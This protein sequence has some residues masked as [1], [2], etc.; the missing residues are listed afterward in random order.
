VAYTT[1]TLQEF[2]NEVRTHLGQP[3]FWGDA[4]LDC[5]V[6]ETLR[7]WNLLTGYWTVRQTITASIGEHWY[8]LSGGTFTLI[9]RVSWMG[10]ALHPVSL[11]ERD[12]ADPGWD[13]STNVGTPRLWMPVALDRFAISPAPDLS[14]R[15]ILVDGV[16]ATPTPILATDTINIDDGLVEPLTH[17]TKHLALFKV[18]SDLFASTE[19]ERKELWE[20]ASAYNS[21]LKST[22]L[23]RNVVGKTPERAFRPDFK[24]PGGTGPRTSE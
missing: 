8:L 12:H 6:R 5:L 3:R 7:Q 24:A 2:R 16:S 17:Y 13:E 23:Y 19:P 10:K 20:A 9:S 15:P 22:N 11:A 1:L 14:G 21:R 18:G 4:E